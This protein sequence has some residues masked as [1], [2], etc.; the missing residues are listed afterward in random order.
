MMEFVN[1]ISLSAVVAL[2]LS[3]LIHGIG[4]NMALTYCV[5]Y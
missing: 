4:T 3:S 2:S 1:F 5:A